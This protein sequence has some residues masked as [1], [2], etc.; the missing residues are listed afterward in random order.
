MVQYYSL[1]LH[2]WCDMI[3]LLTTVGLTLGGSSTVHIYTR[4]VHRT[5][6]WKKEYTE[7]NIHN[8][9]Y[10]E[11]AAGIQTRDPSVQV[12]ICYGAQACYFV[13]L[14][15]TLGRWNIISRHAG[16][17]WNTMDLGSIFLSF[18]CNDSYVTCYW[19]FACYQSVSH[20]YVSSC[21]HFLA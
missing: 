6:Q 1:C 7:Q 5:G 12:L 19:H 10:W 4:T 20:Q 21:R 13:S 3:Y 9:K 18:R 11:T 2:Y 8:N 14:C 16:M 17:F 15:L